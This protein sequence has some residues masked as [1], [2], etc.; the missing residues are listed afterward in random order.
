NRQGRALK[1]AKIL[2]LGVT[3]KADIAD[4]RE[5]PARPVAQR[6]LRHGARLSYHDP[7]VGSW[8]VGQEEIPHAGDDLPAALAAADL[9]IVLAGHRD[10][11]PATLTG[12]ARL[13]LDATGRTRSVPE[14]PAD[15]L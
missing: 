6:L 9:T 12:H 2:L 15:V 1:D 11:D 13:L 5:S 14:N 3:Y 4:Q 7:H 10:Y 8:R